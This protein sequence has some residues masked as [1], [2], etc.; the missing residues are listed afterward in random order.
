MKDR[1]GGRDEGLREE[2]D[3]R[4]WEDEEGGCGREGLVALEEGTDGSSNDLGSFCHGE[5][6]FDVVS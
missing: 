5:C 2:E 4:E 1:G 3:G 6:V